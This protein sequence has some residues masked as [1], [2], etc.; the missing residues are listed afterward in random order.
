MFAGMQA[1]CA[2]A[3]GNADSFG[4]LGAPATVT[5]SRKNWELHFILR[6]RLRRSFSTQ[7]KKEEPPTEKQVQL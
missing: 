7:G 4:Q 3:A 1:P 5:L 6:L 2:K